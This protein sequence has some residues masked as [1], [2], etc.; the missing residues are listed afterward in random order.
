MPSPFNGHESYERLQHVQKLL[1]KQEIRCD[2]LLVVGGADGLYSRG[3]TALLKYLFLGNSGQELLGEQ[4]IPQEYEFLEEVFLLITRKAVSIY[5]A[6]DPDS[7]A[8]ILPLISCW[9]NLTEFV[10]P[11]DATQDDR[12]MTK[13]QAFRNVI[14]T[15]QCIGAPIDSNDRMA[16]EKWPLIQA[17]GL[18]E[19]TSK[20]FFTMNH[21]AIDI[22]MPLMSHIMAVDNYFSHCLVTE[23]VPALKV[24]FDNFMK[25]LDHT[26]HP[27]ERQT[28]SEVE[29]GE[30]LISFYEFGTIRHKARGLDIA[31]Y[32]GSRVLFGT[33]TQDFQLLS[34]NTTADQ[35]GIERFPASHALV[36][37]EEPLT[38][39]RFARTYFLATGK[40]AS[41]VVDVNALV[42]PTF[43]KLDRYD[44][45]KENT[46]DTRLLIE[47]Y[48]LLIQAQQAAIQ[49][50]VIEPKKK[51]ARELAQTV[52][53]KVLENNSL[54]L[55]V[56][57]LE[58]CFH[59]ELECIDA[60]G[61][62]TDHDSTK[63]SQWYLL[64]SIDKVP[65]QVAKGETLGR[66]T[67]GD[68]IL[69]H[70][71][72]YVVVTN[73]FDLMKTW[74]QAGKEADFASHID[75]VLCSEHMLEE[76]L[77]LGREINEAIPHATLMVQS[78]IYP[79][80]KGTLKTYANGFV[81]KSP[82]LNPIVVSF[83]KH[84]A[85]LRVLPTP[86]EELLLLLI[87]FGDRQSNPVTENFPIKLQSST[88]ALPLVTGTRQQTEILGL[89]DKWKASLLRHDIPFYRPQDNLSQEQNIGTTRGFERGIAKVLPSK[90]AADIK[91]QFF[92]QLHI[93]KASIQVPSWNKLKSPSKLSVPISVFLGLPGS[94]VQT[95]AKALINI[96]SNM[97][98]WH[99]VIIDTR[100]YPIQ[101]EQVNAIQ[102]KISS[103]ITTI[104]GQKDWDIRPR[105][106]LT[107]I[108]YI[109][110]ITV[111]A[112]IKSKDFSLPTKVSTVITCLS[113]V[114]IHQTNSC[115]SLP[116][117]WDQLAV[118]FT[119][120]IILSNTADIPRKTLHRLR[121]RID[122]IDPFSD[123]FCL[124]SNVFEGEVSTLLALDAFE[125]KDRQVYR[126]EYYPKWIE[127]PQNYTVA[128]N[129]QSVVL[130]TSA[131][132]DRQR[133]L[134]CFQNGLAPNATLKTIVPV[135]PVVL[136]GLRLAQAI[137][138][139][140]VTQ[141]LPC[142]STVISPLAAQ[143]GSVWS[144]EA[145]VAFEDDPL[146]IYE[147][148]CTGTKATLK[149]MPAPV[150]FTSK[151]SFTGI[152]LDANALKSLL[153]ESCPIKYE[154]IKKPNSSIT[155]QEKRELQ[156]QHQHEPLPDGYFFDGTYYYDYFGNQSEFHPS[157]DIFVQQYMHQ[158]ME[159]A[160]SQSHHL[161]RLHQSIRQLV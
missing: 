109:D 144:T 76:V 142:A 154:A 122:A 143:C 19:I 138:I 58:S 85:S 125:A 47:L 80:V 82:Q 131:R 59:L 73:E 71:K 84:L 111:L 62:F 65:S 70:P 36:V 22:A 117:V 31:K 86:D 74:I 13:I 78:S 132:L 127:Q 94:D 114:C 136:K 83:P 16:I 72:D 92:P 18:D 118:G 101:N 4:V 52:A 37:A 81:F 110:C 96:S 95:L 15:F 69:L 26:A 103:E 140:K 50:F 97:N 98:D 14:E 128:S 66:I 149:P 43:E 106:L 40:I 46:K 151:L 105:I 112:A 12:E 134:Q 129:V 53:L 77:C 29:W 5:Y 68:T 1:D 100:L 99:H 3:S 130:E 161:D 135:H 89:L 2:A 24:H 60:C 133:F 28:K 158:E 9:R 153:L 44:D 34:S 113:S 160:K 56:N 48:S 7:A 41:R 123:V 88:I 54:N 63:W 137:A 155:L 139:N 119:T 126:N 120:A 32:R 75:D 35:A 104:S 90:T 152:K 148:L 79:L 147:Y 121:S 23:A 156:S 67:I 159:K 141:S 91:A 38:G 21:Q 49:S 102:S 124:G 11:E 57:Y 17:F 8:F 51:N 20:G 33:R 108:G 64:L 93:S 146:Q 10:S 107:V 42:H 115:N 27:A 30:D 39:L 87:D 116:K 55:P 61:E 157:I 25:K 145:V 150:S 45:V 6:L